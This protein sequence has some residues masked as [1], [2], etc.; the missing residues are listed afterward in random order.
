[1]WHHAGC[2]TN[3]P[4]MAISTAA[5][6]QQ[7]AMMMVVLLLL[8]LPPVLV[9]SPSVEE[10]LGGGGLLR[11]AGEGEQLSSKRHGGAELPLLEVLLELVKLPKALM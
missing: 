8:L 2:P 9:A 3:S 5:I 6:P 10:L 7:I 1:M 11:G 4:T